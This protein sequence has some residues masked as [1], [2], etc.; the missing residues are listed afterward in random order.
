MVIRVKEEPEADGRRTSLEEVS[1][2]S[3][4]NTGKTS[5]RRSEDARKGS[6]GSGRKRKLSLKSKANEERES[7]ISSFEVLQPTN[8][9]SSKTS[10][11]PGMQYPTP[12]HNYPALVQQLY[13]QLYQMQQ[14]LQAQSH[15]GHS[16]AMPPPPPP[17]GPPTGEPYHPQ[18]GQYL[19]FHQLP[20]GKGK[21]RAAMLV[22][23]QVPN[24][25]SRATSHTKHPL[26]APGIVKA[27][28][29][30]GTGRGRKPKHGDGRLTKKVCSCANNFPYVEYYHSISS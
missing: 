26:G 12:H 19:S 25:M 18:A 3:K 20:L 8:S 24:I 7:K 13:H 10:Y 15:H 14:Q 27:K 29:T 23:G 17:L 11:M 22:P 1:S 21:D 4:E 5:S 30:P 2:S 6:V 16:Y 9:A 28:R